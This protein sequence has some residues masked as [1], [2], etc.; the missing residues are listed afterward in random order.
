MDVVV[1]DNNSSAEEF[2][3]LSGGLPR[4]VQLVRSNEN[5]GYAAG[6]NLGIRYVASDKESDLTLIIN[7]DVF[8]CEKSAVGTLAKALDNETDA[9][10]ISP[11]IKNESRKHLD[12]NTQIQVC[13]CPNY[14]DLLISHSCW[15]RRVWPLVRFWRRH[16][17]W[18]IMPFARGRVYR[19]ESINGCFFIIKTAFLKCIG[20]LDEGTFLYGEEMVL[21]VQIRKMG[22]F[23][24]LH[25]GVTVN[26]LQGATTGATDGLVSWKMQREVIKSELHLCKMYLRVGNCHCAVLLGV[27]LIDFL[28]KCLWRQWVRR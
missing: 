8:L 28:V 6:N 12:P 14:W 15:L 21:A 25:T 27:R 23:C 24:L 26:H 1:V 4:G 19:T 16:T 10:A 20:Y 7:N 17:Y 9:V 13:R 5:R 18:D 2:R 22:K 3:K 11:I